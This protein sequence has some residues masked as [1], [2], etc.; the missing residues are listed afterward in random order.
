MLTN[1]RMNK[2]NIESMDTPQKFGC[3]VLYD[4]KRKGITNISVIP[5]ITKSC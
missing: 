4:I 3:V 5:K 1:S 2:M